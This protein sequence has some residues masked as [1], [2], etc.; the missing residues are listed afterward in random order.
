MADGLTSFTGPVGILLAERDRTAQAFL[1]A[2]DGHDSRI[3]RCPAA[4]HAFVEP[5]AREWLF[6]RITAA[7]RTGG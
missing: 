2:W 1:G 7:L 3:E 4:S 5:E 6:E